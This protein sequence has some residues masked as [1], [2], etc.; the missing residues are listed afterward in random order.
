[1]MKE[2]GISDSNSRDLT[3]T[4]GLPYFGGP[5]SNY[6]LHA[7]ASAVDKIHQNPHYKIMIVANGGYNSKQSF[8]IYG[9]RPPSLDFAEISAINIQKKI[10]NNK[11]N[12]PIEKAK[13]ELTIEGYTILYTR[14]QEPKEGIVIGKI[15]SDQRT[16]AF[17]KESDKKLKA[18]ASKE[19]VN[20]KVRVRYNEEYQCNIIDFE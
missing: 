4:G 20:K 3:L 12:P 9:S 2:I 6:S 19:L 1:M 10:F 14:E 15:N 8:G 16:L 18:L 13:G 5:W 11:I 7:I 17:I